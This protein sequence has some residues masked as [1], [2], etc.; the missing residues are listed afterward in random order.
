MFM[1]GVKE[2]MKVVGLGED[3]ED[4]EMEAHGSLWRPLEGKSRSRRDNNE[5]LMTW[6]DVITPMYL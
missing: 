5:R 6:S 2:D 3:T 1:D 4:G